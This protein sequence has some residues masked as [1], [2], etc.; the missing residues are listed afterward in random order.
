[1][2][3]FF[4]RMKKREVEKARTEKVEESKTNTKERKK[5]RK[6]EM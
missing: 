3:T 6:V 4:P 5:E 2:Q 1:M